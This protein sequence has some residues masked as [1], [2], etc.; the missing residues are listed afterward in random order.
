MKCVKRDDHVF[1]NLR[2]FHILLLR[3]AGTLL[4]VR[5]EN[6]WGKRGFHTESYLFFCVCFVLLKSWEELSQWIEIS[7]MDTSVQTIWNSFRWHVLTRFLRLLTRCSS[8]E[9]LPT[10]TPEIAFMRV[11]DSWIRHSPLHVRSANIWHQ[12]S[13]CL[14]NNLPFLTLYPL[15]SPPSFSSLH[16]LGMFVDIPLTACLAVSFRRRCVRF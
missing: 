13:V 4:G 5:I 9:D 10:R 6:K 3:E 1:F 15:A 8:F 16:V 7:E 2:R 14:F 11:N 12:D